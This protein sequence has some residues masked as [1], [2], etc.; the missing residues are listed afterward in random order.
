MTLDQLS[1]GR[2]AVVQAV[3]TDSAN[4][5]RLMDLGLLPGTTIQCAMVSPL[6]DPKAF[7]IRGALIALRKSQTQHIEIQEVLP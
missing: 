2:S 1:L 3:G 7:E 4:R 5:R 6:G